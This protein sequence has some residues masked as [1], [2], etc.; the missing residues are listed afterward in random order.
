MG[1]A[2]GIRKHGFVSWHERVLLIGHGWLVLTLLCGFVAFA[3]LEMMLI[4]D[5]WVDQARNSFLSL[6]FGL[7]TIA[8]LHRFLRSL[9]RAQ[10]T[11]GQALCAQCQSY[12]KL[13]VVAEDN[14]ATWAR[15]RCRVCSHEWAIDD[16]G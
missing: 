8:S 11:A 7:A 14:A 1:L 9:A 16:P 13:L 10:K 3:A 5:T 15:V 6:A 2:D 12:G 4:S